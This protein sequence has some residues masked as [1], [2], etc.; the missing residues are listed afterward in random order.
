MKLTDEQRKMLT[1]KCKRRCHHTC[2]DGY[3]RYCDSYKVKPIKC[4]QFMPRE[5]SRKMTEFEIY[6]YKNCNTHGDKP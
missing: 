3:L 5:K 6:F 4:D 1:E 2:S